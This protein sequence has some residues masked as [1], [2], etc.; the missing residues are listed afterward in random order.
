MWFH[1][2][3][4]AEPC[5]RGWRLRTTDGAPGLHVA[6]LG[7][8]PGTPVV[9]IAAA[10]GCAAD[11]AHVQQ[12]LSPTTPSLAYDRAGL[13]WSDPR[14]RTDAR[15]LVDELD[16]LIRRVSPEGPVV[17]AGLGHGAWI[18]QHLA[19]TAPARVAGLVLADAPPLDPPGGAGLGRATAAVGPALARIG[20][21]GALASL[22]GDPIGLPHAAADERRRALAQ[23]QHHITAAQEAAA[24]PDLARRIRDLEPPDR[25]LPVAVIATAPDASPAHALQILPARRSRRGWFATAAG[26]A[27]ADLLGPRRSAL[28][29]DAVRHIFRVLH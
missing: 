5:E 1:P 13:G 6:P 27:P 26:A 15:A 10:G 2:A 18:A 25:E 7:A 12:A 3:A 29:V 20:L 24:W 4:P 9:F 23:P 11:W 14:P 21:T 17:L 8:G 22:A 16:E 28:T 19:Q